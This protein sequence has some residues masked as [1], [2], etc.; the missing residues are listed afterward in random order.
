LFGA[1]FVKNID[2]YLSV[3]GDTP[4]VDFKER[5]YLIL[6]SPDSLALMQENLA[7]QRQ[8]GANIVYQSNESLTARFSWL[9]TD[10]LAGGFLGL[11]NEGWLDPYA[12]LQAYR[13]K[14]I[15]LGV[16]IITDE[17]IRLQYRGNRVTNVEL[18]SGGSL[19]RL[20]SFCLLSR[21]SAVLSYSSAGNGSALLRR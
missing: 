5:G 9:A 20:V 13:R 19:N 16:K 15:S 6:A 14:A 10:G 21:V 7:V 3:G 17:V 1:Q 18:V 12:L 4:A 2:Q 11:E 8:I